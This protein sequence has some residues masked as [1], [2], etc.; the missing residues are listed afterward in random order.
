MALTAWKTQQSRL[1]TSSAKAKSAHDKS[2]KPV[3][4]LRPSDSISDG[5]SAL[6]ALQMT[7]R[8]KPLKAFKAKLTDKPL[9]FKSF[10]EK[11]KN[12]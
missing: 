2:K 6:Y 9:Y 7:G 11:H 5:K 1:P 8:L 3:A 12:T 10:I 4:A